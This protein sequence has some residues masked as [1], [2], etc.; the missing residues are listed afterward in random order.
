M[1]AQPTGYSVLG[2]LLYAGAGVFIASFSLLL[3]LIASL[4]GW[5]HFRFGLSPL[6][7]PAVPT[8]RMPLVTSL[9]AFAVINIG[10][11]TASGVAQAV[12]MWA[13]ANAGTGRRSHRRRALWPPA[14]AECFIE[15]H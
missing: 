1:Y 9:V 13:R 5:P 2:L 11:F 8:H 7:P 12:H 15:L 10:L 3:W 4:E 14:V 6:V